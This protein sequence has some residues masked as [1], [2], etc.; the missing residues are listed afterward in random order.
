MA[1]VCNNGKW[2]YVDTLGNELITPRYCDA[3]YFSNNGLAAVQLNGKW[4]FIDKAGTEVIPF[5]YDDAEQF[6][7]GLAEVWR[8]DF[9]GNVDETG[10]ESALFPSV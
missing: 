3:D 2:G 10:N 5:V 1:A 9:H 8:E 6:V 7:N 4:G